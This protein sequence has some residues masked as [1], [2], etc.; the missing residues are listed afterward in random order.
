MEV[1]QPGVEAELQL[2]AYTTA[3]ATLDLSHICDLL[4]SLWQ[5]RILNPLSEARDRTRIFME[6]FILNPLSHSK[7]FCRCLLNKDGTQY[8][9]WWRTNLSSLGPKHGSTIER[10]V[11]HEVLQVDVGE[12][13]L[14]FQ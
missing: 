4:G 3:T 5:H 6:T 11:I 10:S 9:R 1:P 7:N 13:L 12:A 8:G 2:P 14:R